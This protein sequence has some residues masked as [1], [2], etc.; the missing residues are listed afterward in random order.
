LQALKAAFL[1]L[2]AIALLAIFPAR[3]L[4]HYDPAEVPADGVQRPAKRD[5]NEKEAV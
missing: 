5:K 2:A 4:P 3:G 1:I